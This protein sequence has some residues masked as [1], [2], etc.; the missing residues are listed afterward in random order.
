MSVIPFATAWI[1]E[2]GWPV[3]AH[4]QLEAQDGRQ[5]RQRPGFSRM[6]VW[7]SPQVSTGASRA[8][9][10]PWLEAGCQLYT[11]APAWHHQS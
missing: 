2:V 1:V 9:P 10:R 11:P 8:L 7:T 5:N 3:V 6:Q 4:A